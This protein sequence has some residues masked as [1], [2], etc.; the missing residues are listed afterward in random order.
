MNLVTGLLKLIEDGQKEELSEIIN[1]LPL[2]RMDIGKSDNLLSLLLE[3]CA[4][5]SNKE[6]AKIIYDRWADT[7]PEEGHFSLFAYMLGKSVFNDQVVVFMYRSLGRSLY[8]TF[9]ELLTRDDSPDTLAGVIRLINVS[10]KKRSLETIGGLRDMLTEET[11]SLM[12]G[13][14]RYIDHVYSEIAPFGDVPK[15][16]IKDQDELPNADDLE[17][18]EL[19]FDDTGIK[20][21]NDTEDIVNLVVEQIESVGLSVDPEQYE[22]M[23]EE[24]KK[25]P[26]ETKAYVAKETIKTH[27]Y[28]NVQDDEELLKIFG[29]AHPIFDAEL[30]NGTPCGMYG[31]CRMF[32]CVC[33]EATGSDPLSNLDII[34]QPDI[35]DPFELEWFTGSC[36]TCSKR[37]EKKCYAVRRPLETGGWKGCYCGFA[38]V[39]KDLPPGN[40][41]IE[42]L[43][44]AM[45]NKIDKIGIYDR[46]YP[47]DNQ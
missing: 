18:V 40:I 10:G 23:K 38:C 27:E 5:T 7:H 20:I 45:Q 22:S 17:S 12:I 37:I 29:P 15:Y 41:M 43:I 47:E 3:K 8:S 46:V 42:A 26:D 33:F 35:L 32:L 11:R 25:I 24:L 39:R 4:T 2:D 31:G 34:D 44:N 13:V 14:S 21:P 9:G 6:I 36:D 19:I 28:M 30:N 16:I 1:D